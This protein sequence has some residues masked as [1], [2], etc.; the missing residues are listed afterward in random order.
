MGVLAACLSHL[1]FQESGQNPSGCT[2]AS[3]AGRGSAV[4]G[5]LCADLLLSS[6]AGIARDGGARLS[7]RGVRAG[8]ESAHAERRSA[9]DGYVLDRVAGVY[10]RILAGSTL[11]AAL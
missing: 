8:M 5:L 9:R 6:G 3:G 2:A 7:I 11:R 4:H 1:A 10:L